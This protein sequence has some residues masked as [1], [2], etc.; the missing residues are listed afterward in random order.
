MYIDSLMNGS[1]RLITIS[2]LTIG[3]SLTPVVAQVIPDNTLG[4]ENSVV[5]PNVNIRGV[6]SHRIDGGAVRGN[7]LFHS[8]QEFNV[9][10]GRGVYF[11]N[12]E[13]ITN[14]LSRVTGENL[15]QILGTLGVLGNANLFLINPNG[16]VFGPNARL[17]VGGS[18]FATTADSLRFENGF[19]YSSSHPQS[20]PLLTINI[21][22]GLNLRNNSGNIINQSVAVDLDDNSVGLQVQPGQT[23]A[24]IGNQIQFDGGLITAPGGRVELAAV[25]GEGTVEINPNFPLSL[26][27]P[28][29]LIRGDITLT[30]GSQIDVVAP[31]GQGS[32]VINGNNINLFQNSIL[33]AGI[34][35]ESGSPNLQGGAIQLNATDTISIAE[36]SQVNNRL[37]I[38]AQGTAGDII[39]TTRS[40][41]LINGG[42]LNSSKRGIGIGGDINITA[43]DTVSLGGDSNGNFSGIFSEIL[44]GS[45]GRGGNINITTNSLSLTSQSEISTSNFFGISDAG[46]INITANTISLDGRGGRT[47]ILSLVESIG[48]SGNINLN[49]NLITLNQGSFIRN[50]IEPLAVGN[51]GEINL[52]TNSLILTGNPSIDTSTSGR[53]NAGNINIIA[54]DNILISG[55]DIRDVPGI[56]SRVSVNGIGDSGK[57]NVTTGSLFINNGGIISTNTRGEGNAGDIIINVRDTLGLNGEGLF[58]TRIESNTGDL[59]SFSNEGEGTEAGRFNGGNIQIFAKILSLTDGAQIDAST[60]RLGNGGTIEIIARDRVILDGVGSSNIG[61]IFSTISNNG[62]GNGGDITL[63]T[64]LLQINNGANISSSVF[65][66]GNAGNIVINAR[67][68]VS[69]DGVSSNEIIPFSSA[70]ATRIGLEGEG[71]GGDINITTNSLLL[72]NGAELNTSTSNLGNAGNIVLNIRD[73]IIVDRSRIVSAVAP[74]IITFDLFD[75]VATERGDAVGNGG[76]IQIFTPVLSVTNNAEISANTAGI[77][78]AGKIDIQARER[79]ILAGNSQINSAV[80]TGAV[81]NAEQIIIQ[82]PELILRD[83]AQI[84]AA[85]NSQGNAGTIRILDAERV[86]LN[87]SSITTEIEPAATASQP[88]NIEIETRSLELTN[89]S[90]IA[91]STASQGN[92]GSIVISNRDNIELENSTLSTAVEASGKGEGGNIQLTT[93][94]LNLNNTQITA[95]T[96]GE[97]NTGEINLQAASEINLDNSSQINSSVTETGVGNAQKIVLTTSNLNLNNNSKISA[98]TAGNGSAGSIEIQGNHIT[99]NNN[100]SISTAVE[101]QAVTNDSEMI[102]NINIETRSLQLSNHSQMTVSS[103]GEGSAGNLTVNANSINLNQSNLQAETVA[104]NGNITLNTQELRSRRN[105]Q[106][107]T[108]ATGE[109]TGGNIEINTNLLVA[110]E[111]S[112]ISANAQQAFG[113]RVIINANAIFGT[114]FRQQ[115][116]AASD[117]T[118]TSEL[119]PQFSGIVELNSEVDPSSG[120]VEFPQTVID[121]AALIA[122]D[123]CLKARESQFIITGRG[124]IAATPNDPLNANRIE[125]DLVNPLVT[126]RRTRSTVRPSQTS[127]QPI[128]SLDI[129]PARGWIRTEN[130]DVILVGYDPNNKGVQRLPT[131]LKQCQPEE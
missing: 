81:G 95:S 128:S 70:I 37:S 45:A 69:V 114:Q 20:P 53:G 87:N 103:Q 64:G 19:N 83:N 126:S 5:T 131:P 63:S 28:P 4:N 118:A 46:D 94:R 120:L 101:P 2:L 7:N 1:S 52:N 123:L 40:L 61:G 48:N 9:D 115:Q 77:G 93:N 34:A 54:R 75:G 10:V 119:G 16:I 8:F 125:V 15:S 26:I 80:E 116:T 109:A 30:N 23:L 42:R 6:N 82:T 127:N 66:R 104:G 65:G 21:P 29:E 44:A 85:T 33:E 32:I 68:T 60:N 129:I 49:S 41:N 71:T 72:T 13:G 62:V 99:L 59:S 31:E 14:I 106:I 22:L 51:S 113:G 39:V 50:T 108:N 67:D 107:T 3:T 12:P 111:N 96:S 43:S 55:E 38:R 122:Q 86:S 90:I 27:D 47:G 121:P 18:F 58:P 110:I 17:D 100:S 76:N 56:L 79:V 78:E 98:A 73:R 24:L 89:N 57:I 117:I 97:G 36:N 25:S 105:S 84:S 88:S 92:S 124:G 74:E 112:D 11:F 35:T 130:G 91:A 102:G